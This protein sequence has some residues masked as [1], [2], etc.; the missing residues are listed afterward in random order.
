MSGQHLH[1]GNETSPN[2]SRQ[3]E[4]ARIW[5]LSQALRQLGHRHRR[6]PADT[7]CGTWNCAP[8]FWFRIQSTWQCQLSLGDPIL[9]AQVPGSAVLRCFR[10][11]SLEAYS[12]RLFLVLR[13]CIVTSAFRG[14]RSVFSTCRFGDLTSMSTD[15]G[16]LT[17]RNGRKHRIAHVKPG[18]PW[19][20]LLHEFR[21][22]RTRRRMQSRKSA[23]PK[24]GKPFR[25]RNDV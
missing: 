1:N 18:L 22:R 11:D 8:M 7:G 10:A 19:V 4:S 5:I 20:R 24:I 9:D 2:F 15:V 16:L 21:C 23:F 14:G 25:L 12:M 13:P 17:S 3:R 6:G